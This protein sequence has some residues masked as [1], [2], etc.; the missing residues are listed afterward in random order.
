LSIHPGPRHSI[1]TKEGKPIKPK[2]GKFGE[3]SVEQARKM[4]IKLLAEIAEGQD[5]QKVQ[6]QKKAELT[7]AEM[8]A[9]YIDE[10]AKQHCATWPELEASF[11]RYF[12]LWND[13]PLSS[14]D[15]QEVQRRL[16][17]LKEQ[18][19]PA[20]ANKSLDN[21]RAAYNW[22][23][24]FG[25]YE[26]TNPSVGISKFHTQAR[27]R[28]IHPEEFSRFLNTL[29]ASKNIDIRDYAYLSLFTGARQ[30]NV[31]SMR[32]EEIDFDLCLWR[33]PKTKNSR[34]HTIPLTVAAMAVLRE[35]KEKVTGDW[36]FPSK[37][38]AV[39][40]IVEPKVGWRQILEDANIKDLTM[41]D[42][43]RTLGSY[44]AMGNQ[45]LHII[46]K[47]LGH[48]SHTSTQIYARL[49]N[50]PVRQAMEKAQAD[51]MVA[52][53]LVSPADFVSAMVGQANGAEPDATEVVEPRSEAEEAKEASVEVAPAEANKP[54]RLTRVK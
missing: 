43:R 40:H 53:G 39:G 8:F 18:V 26:G 11:R 48:Q 22:A 7:L 54:R 12:G 17:A 3:I 20:T 44:M 21:I 19:G 28:F 6:Q 47:A 4:A 23:I 46:G 38:S 5:P 29:S 13:R 34:S 45:S 24:K 31:L 14:L 27:K 35:R 9:K 36:V 42:L 2:L 1:Y 16:I 15:K 30:S 33:I 52:A 49:A 51:M 10:H 25:Y 37:T 50:D 41:H 32:W